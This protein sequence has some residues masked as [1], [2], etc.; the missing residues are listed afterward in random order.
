MHSA[1]FAL[2]RR[3]EINTNVYDEARKM[4]EAANDMYFEI[5]VDCQQVTEA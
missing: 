3:H 5:I 1:D 4:I 2:S